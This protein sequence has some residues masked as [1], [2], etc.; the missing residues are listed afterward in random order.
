[1]ESQSLSNKNDFSMQKNIVYAFSVFITSILTGILN[2]VNNKK[3]TLQKGGGPVSATP[4]SARATSLSA[5]A[6][7]VSATS[8]SARTTPV[9]PT[10]LTSASPAIF[11][12]NEQSTQSGWLHS[13]F[14]VVDKINT[15]LI[16]SVNNIAIK[17]VDNIV[18]HTLG[19][20]GVNPKQTILDKLNNG[21]TIILQMAND[22]EVQKALT[23][24]SQQL[25]S[26][27]LQTMSTVQPQINEILEKALTTLNQTADKSAKGLMDSGM[28]F[29]TSLIGNIPVYGGIVSL[30]MAFL[31]GFNDAAYAGSPGVE[32]SVD[33]FITAFNTVLKMIQDFN[34]EAQTLVANVGAVTSAVKGLSASGKALPSSVTEF[35]SKGSVLAQ[36]SSLA[37]IPQVPV[38]KVPV[39]Q[40]SLSE[41][42]ALPKVPVAI[43]SAFKRQNGGA[44]LRK[45]I[46]H[47]TRRLKRTINRF[48]KNKKFTR[49]A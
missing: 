46:N 26:M 36:Q 28:N 32:L 49:K 9:S 35:A 44:K 20:L 45:K 17:T 41:V 47:I 38:P 12:K 21:T 22:P 25:T 15:A 13:F 8:L 7:P 18:E 31:R 6:T 2:A 1:M 4:V 29:V 48:M 30:V 33:S 39:P 42:T 27:T 10:T 3:I 19:D 23:G 16:N 11:S 5:R 43:E 40:V 37:N 14:Q 24:L 34:S